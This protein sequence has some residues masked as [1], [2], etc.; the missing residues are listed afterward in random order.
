MVGRTRQALDRLRE[1]HQS[2]DPFKFIIYSEFAAAE[3]QP[4]E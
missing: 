4:V 1:V 2:L 3:L